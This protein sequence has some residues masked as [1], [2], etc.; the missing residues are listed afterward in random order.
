M[1]AWRGW[2]EPC[3]PGLQGHHCSIDRASGVVEAGD[4]PGEAVWPRPRSA[5][6]QPGVQT[7]LTTSSHGNAGCF[8]DAS[9]FYGGRIWKVMTIRLAPLVCLTDWWPKC[10]SEPRMR[11]PSYLIM[12]SYS[13]EATKFV[14]LV[15]FDKRRKDFKQHCTAIPKNV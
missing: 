10:N 9:V 15:T 5:P 13:R 7:T 2:A 11:W 4:P 6:P 1:V 3:G 8:S 14:L 12:A